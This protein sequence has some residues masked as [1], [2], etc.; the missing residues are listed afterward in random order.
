MQ[1]CLPT[2]VTRSLLSLPAL[3]VR[4]PAELGSCR[5]GAVL[6]AHGLAWLPSPVGTVDAG[7]QQSG[8]GAG[9]FAEGQAALE[10]LAGRGPA[11]GRQACA[12]VSGQD[13]GFQ[14]EWVLPVP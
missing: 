11:P 10:E 4:R 7:P 3:G 14:E 9:P 6:G 2:R 12:G 13:S 5:L 1:R 8:R